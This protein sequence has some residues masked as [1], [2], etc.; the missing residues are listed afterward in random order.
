MM[1]SVVR[2]ISIYF[3]DYYPIEM[4]LFIMAGLASYALSAFTYSY[5]ERPFIKASRSPADVNNLRGQPAT[6]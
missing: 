3:T 5:I 6:L 2:R 4:P 1:I